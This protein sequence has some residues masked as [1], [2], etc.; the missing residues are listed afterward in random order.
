MLK[1][2]FFWPQDGGPDR[3]MQPLAKKPMW[4]LANLFVKLD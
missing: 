3:Y 2:K 1:K 4:S